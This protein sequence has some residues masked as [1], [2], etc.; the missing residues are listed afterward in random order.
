[1]TRA[2]TKQ[3]DKPQ[4]VQTVERPMQPFRPP[5]PK[6][7]QPPTP[8]RTNEPPKVIVEALRSEPPPPLPLA[9]ISIFTDSTAG[10]AEPKS[11]GS[12]SAPFGRL[13]V[14]VVSDVWC[15]HLCNARERSL[16]YSNLC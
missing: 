13:M 11:L 5:A 3:T 9:P 15:V 2:R 4:I 12:I 7:E 16:N 14:T 8:P 10:A 1:M 6:P